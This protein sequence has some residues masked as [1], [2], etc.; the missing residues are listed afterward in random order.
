M[1]CSY[2]KKHVKKKPKQKNHT[3]TTMY[4]NIFTLPL[5]LSRTHNRRSAATT[6]RNTHTHKQPPITISI[7]CI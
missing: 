5:F 6:D 2:L 7:I 1:C 3:H 4:T